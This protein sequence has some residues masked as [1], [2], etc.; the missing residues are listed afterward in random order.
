MRLLD[1][2]NVYRRLLNL[3]KVVVDERDARLR[4]DGKLYGL[5][6][7]LRKELDQYRPC[8]RC[9]GLTHVK[10]L[11]VFEVAQGLRSYCAWCKDVGRRHAL[12]RTDGN[13]EVPVTLDRAT[14]ERHLA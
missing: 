11:T 10:R 9:G 7:T 2:V 1:R 6:D 8:F 14:T 13:R 4:D 5:I 3:E 12:K